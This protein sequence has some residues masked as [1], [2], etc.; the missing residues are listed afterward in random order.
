VAMLAGRFASDQ[1][2]PQMPHIVCLGPRPSA[3][4][5]RRWHDKHALPGT[6]PDS[7]DYPVSAKAALAVVPQW[8][9]GLRPYGAAREQQPG[10]LQMPQMM[11]AHRVGDAVTAIGRQRELV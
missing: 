11:R 8:R 4:P 9:S 5:G 10:A 1:A 7:P 2:M 3:P 6:E